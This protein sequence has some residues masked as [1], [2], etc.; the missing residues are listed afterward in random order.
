MTCNVFELY[1]KDVNI[2]VERL[3]KHVRDL[4]TEIKVEHHLG[5]CDYYWEPKLKWFG[6]LRNLEKIIM[7]APPDG[8]F[9]WVIEIVQRKMLTEAAKFVTVELETVVKYNPAD[10]AAGRRRFF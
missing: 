8:D 9:S 10:Y 6:K 7:L 3:P 4:I 1:S 2:F 5:W